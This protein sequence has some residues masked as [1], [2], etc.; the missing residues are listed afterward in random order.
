MDELA[1]A[2]DGFWGKWKQWYR[3]SRLK[4]WSQ[5]IISCF[6]MS[7]S[8]PGDSDSSA[9]E[10]SDDWSYEAPSKEETVRECTNQ[11]EEACYGRKFIVVSSGKMDLAPFRAE[12]GD[13]L[14]YF[15]GGSLPLVVR[16]KIDDDNEEAVYSL[17][18]DC[19]VAKFD[20]SKI[21]GDP[22]IALK[23]FILA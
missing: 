5:R 15:P 11:V 4:S 12:V 16:P 20:A 21:M 13:L 8:Q 19:Y 10:D 18:G 17:I 1:Y 7:A 14:V 6:D 3:K 9:T 22:K 23:K 2:E